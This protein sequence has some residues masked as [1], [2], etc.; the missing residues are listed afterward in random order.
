LAGTIFK[1]V[2]KILVLNYPMKRDGIP[3]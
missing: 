1:F 3:Y 2:V